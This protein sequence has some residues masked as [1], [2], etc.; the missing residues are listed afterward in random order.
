[1]EKFRCNVQKNIIHGSLKNQILSGQTVI[2]FSFY[3]T[4]RRSVYLWHCLFMTRH[5]DINVTAVSRHIG[6]LVHGIDLS[7]ALNAPTISA[8]KQLLADHLVLFFHDQQLDPS[9]LFR[10]AGQLGTPVPYPY[11]KGMPDFPEIVEVLKL[12]AETQ[13]FGGVWH[14]DTTYLAS[15][16]MGALL[17]AVEVPTIGGDTLF[18]NMYEAFNCLSP[19]MKKFLESLRSV[20]DA[21]KSDIAATRV[22]RQT[23]T[24]KGLKATHPVVRT[25]PVTGR[26]LLYVNKAHTTRFEGMSEAESRPI[27]EYLFKAVEAPEIGCRFSWRRG[28]LAFW[29]NR[30]CQHYP[31]NDYHGQRRLMHRISLAGEIPV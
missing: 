7:V 20:N 17:Y 5:K 22:D 12:P 10:L 25:H 28:S 24:L 19:G 23:T 18:A 3:Y 21:D 30:S 27:L 31:L 4:V 15:P 26:K 9:Q 6:A 16:T 13:N 1:M 11:V 14:S 29:D 2:T 8:I